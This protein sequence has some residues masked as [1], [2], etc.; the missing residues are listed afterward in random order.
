MRTVSE[1]IFN[2][3]RGGSPPEKYKYDEMSDGKPYLLTRGEDFPEDITALNAITAIRKGFRK[4]NLLIR[5]SV[6]SEDE[7][8]IQVVGRV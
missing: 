6:V 7:I 1:D 3:R 8:A 5:G 2:K 4:R